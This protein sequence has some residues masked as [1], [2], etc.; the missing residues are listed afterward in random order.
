MII[1]LYLTKSTFEF[2]G[3][4]ENLLPGFFFI[5][6]FVHQKDQGIPIWILKERLAT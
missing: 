2:I 1:F 3:F 5:E 6:P 4:P